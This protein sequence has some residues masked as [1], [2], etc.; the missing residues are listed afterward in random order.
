MTPPFNEKLPSK[1]VPYLPEILTYML[2]AFPSKTELNIFAM[3]FPFLIFTL[4][5]DTEAFTLTG[6]PP[7][8]GCPGWNQRKNGQSLTYWTRQAAALDGRGCPAPSIP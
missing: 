8:S 5:R 3:S 7:V 2:F 4:F 6:S 1:P